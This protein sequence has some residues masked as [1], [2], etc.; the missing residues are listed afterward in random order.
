MADPLLIERLRQGVSI[1]NEWKASQNTTP[2][3]AQFDSNGLIR[4]LCRYC[5][6]FS[7]STLDGT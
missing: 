7:V 6:L 4:K 5:D 3:S 1:W 2:T